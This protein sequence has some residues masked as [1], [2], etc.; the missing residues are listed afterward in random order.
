MTLE[1]EKQIVAKNLLKFSIAK[2][3]ATLNLSSGDH[4]SLSKTTSRGNG[5]ARFALPIQRPRF[6]AHRS[7]SPNTHSTRDRVTLREF[8]AALV[9]NFES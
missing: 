8:M 5:T 4:F 1:R 2:N 6:R 9:A 7:P 3:F